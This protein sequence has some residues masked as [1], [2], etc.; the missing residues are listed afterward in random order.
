MLPID[1]PHRVFHNQTKKAFS[2]SEIVV[3]GI[4]NE[5][6][7]DG[8]Y[9]PKTLSRIYELTE[10]AKTLR[11]PDEK[12][13]GKFTGVIEADMVAP[14]MTDHMSQ[15]GPGVIRFEWL[16]SKPPKTM[17]EALAIR[18]KAFFE[19]FAQ[20]PDVLPRRQGHVHLPAPDR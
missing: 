20:G 13:P 17:A 10:F 14:S 16:M 5:H 8:V 19:S 4:V 3:L 2:L 6:D 15:G 9:N 18:D 7:P 1:E 11:W 12:N